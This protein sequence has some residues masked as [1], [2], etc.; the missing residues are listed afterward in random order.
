MT[1]GLSSMEGTW[2][3]ENENFLKFSENELKMLKNN[4]INTEQRQSLF[5]FLPMWYED[6]NA[7]RVVSTPAFQVV[8]LT[9]EV[10]PRDQ[11]LL[12]NFCIQI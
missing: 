9:R 2:R 3:S 11:K 4:S 6:T 12:A 1:Q 7:E 5:F 10:V 8:G